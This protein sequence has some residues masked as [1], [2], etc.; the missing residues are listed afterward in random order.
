N[1][2]LGSGGIGGVPA[3]W[4]EGNMLF[5]VT[6]GSGTGGIAGGVIGLN[7]NANCT[8]SVAWSR[9]M[10]G[11]TQP[12]STPTVANGIVFAGEGLNGMIHAFD[13]RT[14]SPLWSSTSQYGAAATYAA[15]IVA[16]GHVYA[17]S[18]SNF[19]GGGIVGA[20]SLAARRPYSPS[21]RSA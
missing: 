16:Q 13:A 6:A 12:N 18:W 4:A 1:D 9:A 10:G 11:G 2:W 19:S 20:F 3:Y 21:P 17:G 7:V 5:V 15:P 14:G 8:L